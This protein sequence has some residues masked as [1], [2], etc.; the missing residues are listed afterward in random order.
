MR[1]SSAC[2]RKRF[3]DSS[4]A[5]HR[6]DSLNMVLDVLRRAAEE[7]TYSIREYS[8]ESG[9]RRRRN[10][11]FYGRRPNLNILS[12]YFM[13]PLSDGAIS[14]IP[15]YHIQEKTNVNCTICLEE[16]ELGSRVRRLPCS[17]LYHISCIDQW[18][19]RNAQ[20]PNCRTN[21]ADPRRRKIGRSF[22]FNTS[23][24]K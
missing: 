14:V 7:K 3:S 18:L 10:A 6:K 9:S 16:L 19:R 23:E 4:K 21:I 2:R 11:V 17:H 13:N 22:L 5:E 24:N 20:C 15:S 1:K 12:E 8:V